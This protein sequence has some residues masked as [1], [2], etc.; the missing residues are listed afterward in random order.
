MSSSPW[1]EAKSSMNQTRLDRLQGGLWAATR[2]RR[3]IAL[4]RG[5]ATIARFAGLVRYDES[6]LRRRVT[7]AV[8]L[9]FTALLS[10]CQKKEESLSLLVWEGYADPSFVHAFEEA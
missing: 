4:R 6:W 9:T 1:S 2:T 5:A 7:L 10:S 8:I 3:G